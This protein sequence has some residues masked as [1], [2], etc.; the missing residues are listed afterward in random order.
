MRAYLVE[1]SPE[2]LAELFR[3]GT[4]KPFDISYTV[5]AGVPKNARLAEM[6][7]PDRGGVIEALFVT[8][9]EGQIPEGVN[10]WGYAERKSVMIETEVRANFNVGEF[11]Y[12]RTHH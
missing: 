11:T 5:T 7:W 6:R 4:T 2:L 10:I 1:I 9:E 3:E 12:E 8:D